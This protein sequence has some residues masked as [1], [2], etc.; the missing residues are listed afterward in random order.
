MSI[1]KTVL[2]SLFVTGMAIACSSQAHELNAETVLKK[3]LNQAL[4]SVS[5]E[6]SEEVQKSILT[7]VHNFSFAKE[8]DPTVPETTVSITD[9]MSFQTDTSSEDD[10]VNFSEKS[11]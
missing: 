3:E 9:L 7:S 10:E 2:A 5:A 8:L 1:Q 4:A 11:D 6:I